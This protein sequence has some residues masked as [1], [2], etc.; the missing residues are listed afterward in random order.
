M[1][2]DLNRARDSVGQLREWDSV[3]Q[4]RERDNR[5]KYVCIVGQ[6]LN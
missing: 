6:G 2:V 1:L 3:G 4:L 5:L